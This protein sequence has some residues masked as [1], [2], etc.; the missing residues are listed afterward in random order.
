MI[1]RAGPEPESVKHAVMLEH[2][3]SVTRGVFPAYATVRPRT[4]GNDLH[5]RVTWTL[6]RRPDKTSRPV[7]VRFY[8][9]E[10]VTY[11]KLGGQQ[12]THAEAR[13][14]Q[15]LAKKLAGF[16]PEH[17]LSPPLLPEPEVWILPPKLF[18][19]EDA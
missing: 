8:G 3:V 14:T 10:I 18:S 11:S 17:D 9:A 13:L 1:E 6:S 15:F 7:E 16:D 5:L 19:T 12:R 2:I 4:V